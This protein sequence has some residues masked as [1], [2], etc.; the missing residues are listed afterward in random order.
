MTGERSSCV[1]LPV[2]ERRFAYSDLL[3]NVLLVKPEVRPVPP[4]VL[5]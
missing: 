5:S 3:G 4:E 1:A 2:E